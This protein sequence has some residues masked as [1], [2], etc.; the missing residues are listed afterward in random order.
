MKY[1]V[2]MLKKIWGCLDEHMY[3]KRSEQYL[4][5]KEVHS[6]PTVSAIEGNELFVMFL[7]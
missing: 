4:L 1:F 5:A 2:N 7:F 3:L 6:P